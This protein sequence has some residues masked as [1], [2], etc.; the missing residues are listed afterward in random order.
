MQ[1]ASTAHLLGEDK[2]SDRDASSQYLGPTAP[3]TYAFTCHSTACQPSMSR[4]PLLLSNHVPVASSTHAGAA[5]SACLVH[6][7]PLGHDAVCF[8]R[9]IRVIR[10]R[11]QSVRRHMWT[12]EQASC[13]T[14]GSILPA[15]TRHAIASAKVTW[16]TLRVANKARRG[17]TPA[18]T[19][20]RVLLKA[21]TMPHA[22][23]HKPGSTVM[24][25]SQARTSLWPV[26]LCP[27]MRAHDQPCMLTRHHLGYV[28]SGKQHAQAAFQHL[29]HG[30]AAVPCAQSRCPWRQRCPPPGQAPRTSCPRTASWSAV[31]RGGY[32]CAL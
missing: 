25:R 4:T 21:D 27:I 22:L 12:H 31:R 32:T 13:P 19:E 16:D 10:E 17:S 9:E 23:M 2:V 15:T 14:N 28:A 20:D 3:P 29:G 6:D 24:T 8:L 11:Q 5:G 30:W 18:T 7:P 1:T 26:L